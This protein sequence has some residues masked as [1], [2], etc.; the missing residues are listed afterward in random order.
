MC[1]A[2]VT[3]CIS[4]LCAGLH[5]RGTYGG[6]SDQAGSSRHPN[7]Q[8]VGACRLGRRHASGAVGAALCTERAD[9]P[10]AHLLLGFPACVLVVVP[11]GVCLWSRL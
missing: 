10:R 2:R 7:P 11:F 1:H 5:A 6:D 3:R 4:C 9:V 8:G